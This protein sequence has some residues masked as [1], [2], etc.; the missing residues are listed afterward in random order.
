MFE[1]VKSLCFLVPISVGSE[2]FMA[3]SSNPAPK[4]L[5]PMRGRSQEKSMSLAAL[6]AQ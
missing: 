4:L 5:A 1:L 6:E 3:N 2:F